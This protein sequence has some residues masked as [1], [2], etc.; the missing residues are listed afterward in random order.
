MQRKDCICNIGCTSLQKATAAI[1]M[2]AYGTAADSMDE[3][4]RMGES[5]VLKCIEHFCKGVTECFGLN[6]DEALQKKTLKVFSDVPR[7]EDFRV[8]L[9]VLIVRSGFGKTVPS[10]IMDSTKGRRGHPR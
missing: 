9:A 6:T 8:C 10:L 4:L 3:Y 2:L 1:R 7:G 5:T